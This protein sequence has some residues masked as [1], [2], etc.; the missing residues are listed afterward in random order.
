MHETDVLLA[1][2]AVYAAN[3]VG[4]ESPRRLTLG[5]VHKGVSGEV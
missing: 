5:Y 1:V 2:V 3:L 4:L